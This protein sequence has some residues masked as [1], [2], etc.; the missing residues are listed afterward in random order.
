MATD[1]LL[2]LQSSVT[3][4]ATFNGS[5]LTLASG[6]PRRGLVARVIYSA[7]STGSGTGSVTF[8]ID[9]SRDGGSTWNTEFEGPAISLS[10]TAISGEQNIPFSISP[11]SVANGTQIRLSVEAISGTSATVTYVGDLMPGRP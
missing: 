10:T 2:S 1:S 5:A 9:V 4:T 6:T 7:A 11:T 8:G 3:K